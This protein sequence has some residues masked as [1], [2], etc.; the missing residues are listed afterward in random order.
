M[1][2]ERI[3]AIPERLGRVDGHRSSGVAFGFDLFLGP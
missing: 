3:D 2:C 1:D